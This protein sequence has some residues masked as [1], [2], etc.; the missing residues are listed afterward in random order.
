M[1]RIHFNLPRHEG[2][3]IEYLGKPRR[4]GNDLA[5]DAP[6]ARR[7]TG[8]GPETRIHVRTGSIDG[9]EIIGNCY[10][11]TVHERQALDEISI[12][13]ALM[14]NHTGF[15]TAFLREGPRRMASGV[16]G[17]EHQAHGGVGGVLSEPR[18]RRPLAL[19]MTRDTVHGNRQPSRRRVARSD[20]AALRNPPRT[21]VPNERIPGRQ[22]S[23]V[24]R[25]E[26]CGADS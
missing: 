8:D 21:T 19:R 2:A 18:T 24:K 7:R 11:R 26:F 17:A 16:L 20:A 10:G 23:I 4:V 5:D 3:E 14:T 1:H 9:Q 15:L 13:G 12:L 22:A 6:H 25:H